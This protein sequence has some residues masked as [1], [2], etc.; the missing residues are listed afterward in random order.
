MGNG[1]K[2]KLEDLRVMARDLFIA[3]G[4]PQDWAQA[5]ADVLVW[6]DA[7]G[8]GSHGVFRIPSYLAGMR[9]GLRSGT[10]DIRVTLRKGATAILEADKG[11][12]LYAMRKAADI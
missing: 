11:P 3:A 6:A 1:V 10:A 12:G 9:K 2:I 4:L 8:V 7:R 5:E